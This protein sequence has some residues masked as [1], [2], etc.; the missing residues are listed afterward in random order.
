ML[1]IIENAYQI[2][3]KYK[4]KQDLDV[5]THCC[6]TQEEKLELEK[7]Y[8]KEISHDLIYL[9]NTAA[10]SN[11]PP[12]EEFK[13]FLP[14][15]LELISKNKFPSHSIELSLKRI[16]HYEKEEFT[17]EE[18]I[19]IEEFCLKYFEQTISNYPS[20][21][22]EGIDSILIM[23]Y[24]ANC[25]MNKILHKWKND[26]SE[27]GNR[28]F[29]DFVNH[30]LSKRVNKINNPFSNNKLDRII[31]NWLSDDKLYETKYDQIS[32]ET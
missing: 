28:H 27:T 4:L 19:V 31:E 8:L 10:T 5:C 24:D 9:H 6:V 14:R 18:L 15:Y 12:I 11:K 22:N 1:E 7:Q 16:K 30:G 20:P 17:K 29:A 26:N 13:Y 23:L 3:G 2:F 25:D 32:H 21:E